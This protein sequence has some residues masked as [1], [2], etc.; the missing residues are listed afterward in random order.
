[1]VYVYNGSA[2]GPSDA[3][4]WIDYPPDCGSGGTCGFGSSLAMGDVNGDGYDD[5]AVGAINVAQ[6]KMGKAHLFLG[7]PQGL[8]RTPAWSRACDNSPSESCYWFGWSLAMGDVNGDSYK[9]L[10]V[11]APDYAVFIKGKWYYIGR[12][13]LFLGSPSGLSTTPAWTSLG[14]MVATSDEY[15]AYGA[16]LALC[17]FNRDGYQDLVVGDPH[18]NTTG[19]AYLFLG[20]PSGLST[21][22]GWTSMGNELPEGFFADALACGDLNRD[23]YDD[24]AVLESMNSGSDP[25]PGNVMAFHGF[26]WGLSSGAMWNMTVNGTSGIGWGTPIASAIAMGDVNG[27]GSS[28]LLVGAPVENRS[29][30]FLGD[31]FGLGT[32]PFWTFSNGDEGGYFGFA[33]AIGDINGDG[34]GEVAIGADGWSSGTYEG[35]QSGKAYVFLGA[36]AGPPAGRYRRATN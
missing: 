19:K 14:E 7:S 31:P 10:A 8:S 36:A 2:D 13:Y 30:L 5:L 33:L 17:D 11:G 12:A 34:K 21:T 18:R 6:W 27:D 22:P 24:L 26:P 28:D 16:T 25:V 9:D 1:M 20:S 23:G 4:Y 15:N 32:S 35:E 3:G 29:H